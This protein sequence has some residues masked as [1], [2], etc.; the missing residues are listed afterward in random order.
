MPPVGELH[1]F[2]STGPSGLGV[3][4]AAVTAHHFDLRM[5]CQPR[6]DRSG[7]AALKHLDRATGPQVHDDRG[8]DVATA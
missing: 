3:G 7:F 4:P 5:L 6:R 2:R 8:V 1:C